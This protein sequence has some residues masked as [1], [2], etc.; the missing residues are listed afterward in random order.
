MHEKTLEVM[1]LQIRVSRIRTEDYISLTDIA[2]KN[3]DDKPANTVANW[4]RNQ[5][6]LLYLQTWEEVHNPDFKVLQMQD[7]KIGRWKTGP[8]F[9]RKI[10]SNRREPSGWFRRRG[11]TAAALLPTAKSRWNSALGFPRLSKSIST[12][13]FSG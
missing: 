1:G 8:S 9:P 6:T 5:N 4:L 12:K 13:N 10:T 2:R 11:S 7:F 3:S